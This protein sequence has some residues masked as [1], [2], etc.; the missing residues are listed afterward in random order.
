ME[1][2]RVA[3]H[4]A[5][6]VEFSPHERFTSAR[7]PVRCFAW[8]WLINPHT[9]IKTFKIQFQCMHDLCCRVHDWPRKCTHHYCCPA[10]CTP[11]DRHQPANSQFSCAPSVRA[12]LYSMSTCLCALVCAHTP[13]TLRVVLRLAT[14]PAS[15][16]EGSTPE[17]DALASPVYHVWLFALLCTRKPSFLRAVAVVAV[18]THVLSLPLSFVW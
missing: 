13:S 2:S 8:P 11:F 5:A 7:E 14:E 1:V 10:W 17:G 9:C 3:A 12:C 4:C 18:S 15:L 6:R 16:D